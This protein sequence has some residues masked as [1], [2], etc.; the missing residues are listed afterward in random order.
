MTN[1]FENPDGTYRVLVNDEGQ[2][3]LWPDFADV[4]AGWAT[5]F[6][7]EGRAACLEYIERE[8]TDLRPKSL[9][10]AMGE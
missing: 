5:L 9:V 7:P 6:G 3:S 2:H 8:W 4:P 10:Q 1:P